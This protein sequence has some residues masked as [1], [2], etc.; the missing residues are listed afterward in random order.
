ME[1]NAFLRAMPK[2]SLHVHLMGSIQA[3]TVVELAAKHNVPLPD[4]DEP[5][6]LY[7]YPDIY[8]FLH[9]YDNSA[10]A[11]QDRDDFRR[12]AYET[13]AEAADH[14]HDHDLG[15]LREIDHLRAQEHDEVA[16]EATR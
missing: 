1:M 8:K 10:L 5:E 9:M 11:V 12:I 13:L 16:I 15:H 14:N 6:D 2:V 7:D 3:R 4:F